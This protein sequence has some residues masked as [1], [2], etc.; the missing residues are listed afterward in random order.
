MPGE[1]RKRLD[2][3]PNGA[4]H[5]SIANRQATTRLLDQRN[6]LG[7][8]SGT[9]FRERLSGGA[10]DPSRGVVWAALHEGL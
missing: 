3:C 2:R 1:C 4:G 7:R 10:P 9:A 8:S 6:Y 5:P